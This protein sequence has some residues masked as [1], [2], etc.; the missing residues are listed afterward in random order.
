[1]AYP[2]EYKS[3]DTRI[4]KFEADH[5]QFIEYRFVGLFPISLKFNESIISKLTSIKSNLF[6]LVLTD[7]FVVKHHHCESIRS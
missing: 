2:E 5:F 1:M 3:N 7:I 4:V 6:F